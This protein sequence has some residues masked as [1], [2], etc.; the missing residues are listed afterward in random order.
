MSRKLIAILS[1]VGVVVV[2]GLIVVIIAVSSS[3]REVRLWN[4]GTAQQTNLKIVFDETWK[5]IQQTAQV[6][7]QYK[8]AFAEIYPKLM[9]ARYAQEGQNLMMKMITES[10]PN[11]DTKLYQNLTDQ[12]AAKR[13]KFAL[14]QK[15]MTDLKREHD[16]IETTWP[17]SMFV[18][19]R[20]MEIQIVTSTKTENAFKT[21]KEDDVD[22]FKK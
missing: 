4:K 2:L 1:T 17:S 10:N 14:E 11:F 7:D 16:D 20:T 8:V 22:L 19:K 15:A 21:G 13:A 5:V 3:N 18:K 6:A 12:I 9:D